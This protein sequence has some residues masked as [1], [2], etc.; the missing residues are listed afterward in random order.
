MKRKYF[1]ILLLLLSFN[2]CKAQNNISVIAYYTGGDNLDSF[3]VNKLTHIIFSFC[4]LKRNELD[5][6][7]ARDSAEMSMA[8]WC[9]AMKF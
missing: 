2:L 9:W 6:R 1:T 7:N 4:H 3:Q 5:V 8:N